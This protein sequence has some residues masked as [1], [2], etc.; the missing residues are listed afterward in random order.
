MSIS[1]R[2]R[3]GSLAGHGELWPEVM[4]CMK[5]AIFVIAGIRKSQAPSSLTATVASQG[6][7]CGI[8]WDKTSDSLGRNAV[9]AHKVSPCVYEGKK[10]TPTVVVL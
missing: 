5:N 8:Q 9:V 6:K 2:D 3:N 10:P 7:V 4:A 1:P